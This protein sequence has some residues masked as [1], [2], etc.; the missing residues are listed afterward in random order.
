MKKFPLILTLASSLLLAA[1]GGDPVISSSAPAPVSSNEPAVSSEPASSEA[2]PVVTTIADIVGGKHADGDYVTVSGIITV[3][4]TVGTSEYLSTDFS[5]QVGSDALT[6][7]AYVNKDLVKVG[8]SVTATG[9]LSVS[10]SVPNHL[11]LHATSSN[12]GSIAISEQT[13]TYDVITTVSSLEELDSKF[14]CYAELSP[15]SFVSA[16]EGRAER[17]FNASFNGLE[18]MVHLSA[19]IGDEAIHEF[20]SAISSGTN[21]KYV[22]AIS[23]IVTSSASRFHIDSLDSVTLLTSEA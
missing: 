2:A 5:L 3:I 15:I 17:F 10:T 11:I 12:N 18:F 1:C 6:V 22:G 14:G 20:V 9:V 23:Y 21:F 8:S 19:S 7:Y 13:Y 16:V 4:T